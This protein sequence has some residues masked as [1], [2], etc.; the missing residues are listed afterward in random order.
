MK[1]SKEELKK[2]IKEEL[3]FE[4]KA[5]TN[6]TAEAGSPKPLQRGDI[7]EDSGRIYLILGRDE[8]TRAAWYNAWMARKINYG[9]GWI[10]EIAPYNDTRDK[11]QYP[12][13]K[14]RFGAD[15]GG[16]VVYKRNGMN[17]AKYEDAVRALELSM[18]Q[19]K[20]AIDMVSRLGR[21]PMA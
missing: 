16:A 15:I 2:I 17:S 7:V 1:I 13:S 18:K 9:D 10:G 12:A 4:A 19:T 6:P 3:E 21:D 20:I 8:S 11:K 5:G 14:G